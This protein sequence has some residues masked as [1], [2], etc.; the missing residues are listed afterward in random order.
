MLQRDFHASSSPSLQRLESR[1]QKRL[2]GAYFTPDALTEIIS[3]WAIRSPADHVLEPSFGGCGFLD[4]AA[5]RLR[6]LGCEAPEL[7]IYGCD[8]APSA[9]DHLAQRMNAVEGNNFQLRDYLE[10]Q[11]PTGWPQHFNVVIGNPPYVSYHNLSSE[12]R[13]IAKKAIQFSKEDLELPGNASLWA[14]FLVKSLR[15]VQTGGRLAMVLPRSFIDADYATSLR[16][17]IGRSFSRS[18]AFLI[19]QQIFKSVGAEERIVCL[20]ADGKLPAARTGSIKIGA[21]ESVA[22]LRPLI[23]KWDQKKWR[24]RPVADRA[25]MA[26]IGRTSTEAFAEV[27]QMPGCQ[28]LGKFCKIRIGLVTGENAFFVMNHEKA[29]SLL[30]PKQNFRSVV[31]RYADIGGAVFTEMDWVEAMY[32]GFNSLLLSVQPRANLAAATRAYLDSFDLKKKAENK[33]FAKRTLWHQIDDG[34]IPDAFLSSMHNFGPRLSLNES[35]ANCTN[36]LFRV[37]FDNHLSRQDRKLIAI[38]L[39]TTFSQLS[40]EIEG[41]SY[42]SG[43][44]KHEPSEAGKIKLLLPPSAHS[45]D[46]D[47][48]FDQV[49]WALRALQLT[50]AQRIADDF[51]LRIGCGVP[52]ASIRFLERGLNKLRNVRRRT[53]MHGA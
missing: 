29:K 36:T 50:T 44:L 39:L 18:A 20:L 30:L 22:E 26:F 45:L 47:A 2:L 52:E 23:L 13:T 9:F 3:E 8:I 11:P 7:Q 41:R 48:T 15:D 6:N 38:S 42:G 16:S 19:N 21:V 53:D 46:I 32:A 40:A 1:V 27:S 14:Y 4:A 5:S 51:I 33:T 37:F 24:G 25:S 35:T 34:R 12:Q 49:D 10:E 43:V 17:Y 31:T 28:L